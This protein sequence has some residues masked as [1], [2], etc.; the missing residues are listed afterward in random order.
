MSRA[1]KN[2]LRCERG[3]TAVEFGFVL[4][5]LVLLLL[6]AMEFG[7]AMWVQNAL[8]YS[9]EQAARCASIN[10]TSCG[11][12]Q[13]TQ[14]FAAAAAGAGFT[15][16]VFTVTNSGGCNTVTASYPFTINVPF[17]SRSITL[18]AQSC[19]PS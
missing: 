15:S 19:Y 1:G 17:V 8:N 13:N 4:I 14:T 18:T 16:S 9:V 12:T 2:I 5:P 6:G 11:T 3:S 10:A 7:R